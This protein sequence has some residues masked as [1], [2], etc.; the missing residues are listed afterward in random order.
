MEMKERR[1]AS[2]FQDLYPKDE[3]EKEKE[4]ENVCVP[5]RVCMGRR[6]QGM[7]ERVWFNAI[8]SECVEQE[9]VRESENVVPNLVVC[10]SVCCSSCQ[11]G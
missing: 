6:K 8:E 7:R 1:I 11:G 10:A 2:S 3:R 4:R 5:K 9:S